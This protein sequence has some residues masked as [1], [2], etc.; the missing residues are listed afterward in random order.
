MNGGDEFGAN[1]VGVAMGCASTIGCRESGAVCSTVPLW[2]S[3]IPLCESSITGLRVL[4]LV[5]AKLAGTAKTEVSE[6]AAVMTR[7]DL[8]RRTGNMGRPVEF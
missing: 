2:P 3:L 6:V 8:S 7:M 1:S 4:L 5:A